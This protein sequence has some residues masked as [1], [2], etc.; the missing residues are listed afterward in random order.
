MMTRG[1]PKRG[2]VQL[3][4][5]RYS[6][7]DRQRKAVRHCA[8]SDQACETRR[9]LEVSESALAGEKLD[10][11][12]YNVLLNLEAALSGGALLVGRDGALRDMAAMSKH[13]RRLQVTRSALRL[14]AEFCASRGCRE[15]VWY[16]DRP[17][18]NSG[19]LR[20]LILELADDNDWPWQVHLV[21]DPDRTLA[22]SDH[23][24]ASSDSRI[25]EQCQRWFNL[26]RSIVEWRVPEA[27]IVDLA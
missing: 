17:I 27:W 9:R 20:A 21:S 3:V 10:V 4:G 6:L 23:I 16:F 26:T 14:A 2:A 22:G 24:V 18:S 5:D 25:L 1:Y 8:A 13:Y 12:G 11:D 19:K 15:V 7:R